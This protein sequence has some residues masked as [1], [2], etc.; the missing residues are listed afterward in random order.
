MKYITFTLNDTYHN[1]IEKVMNELMKCKTIE[2]VQ[3]L[4]QRENIYYD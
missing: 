3:K 4:D 2:D 1:H